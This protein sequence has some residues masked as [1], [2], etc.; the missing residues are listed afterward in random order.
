M[1]SGGK[2]THQ[3]GTTY[4]TVCIVL[5]TRVFSGGCPSVSDDDMTPFYDRPMM[6]M[7]MRMMMMMIM[8]RAAAS[9]AARISG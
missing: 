2:A 5:L 3:R 1:W 6:M 4:T 8:Q 9:G 7:M